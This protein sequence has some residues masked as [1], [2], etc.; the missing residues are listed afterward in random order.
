MLFLK[1]VLLP[2]IFILLP[3]YLVLKAHCDYVNV[4]MFNIFEVLDSIE[5][6]RKK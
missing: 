5:K 1:E 2:A 6:I 3:I 4:N